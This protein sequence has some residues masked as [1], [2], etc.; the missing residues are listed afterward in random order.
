MG[1]SLL[2]LEMSIFHC[3]STMIGKP[4]WQLFFSLHFENMIPLVSSFYCC[5][6]Y[7]PK[8]CSFVG[9]LFSLSQT[10]WCFEIS[11]N[12]SRCGFN[13]YLFCLG[14][15]V[16]LEFSIVISSSA[17]FYQESPCATCVESIFFRD[18]FWGSVCVCVCVFV[19]ACTSTGV[20]GV[21]LA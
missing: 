3:F 19:F 21:S 18:V 5:F 15:S 13:F 9:K 11:Y 7:Q 17:G 2:C 6:C 14:L 10:L 16:N 12:I 8:C 1:G 4:G 20:L